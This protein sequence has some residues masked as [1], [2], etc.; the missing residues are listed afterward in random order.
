MEFL[1]SV[2]GK[3]VTGVVVLAVVAMGISWFQMDDQSR[4]DLLRG[5]G[6][7]IAW[8]GVVLVMPWIGFAV[9]NAVARRESNLA[10]GALIAAMTAIES[11]GLAWLFNW[12][13]TG[14]AAWMFFVLA[15]LIAGVYNLFTC[16][17]IAEK[18]A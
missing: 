1:K 15:V 14:A 7:I 4:G 10:G 6:R 8:L 3:A 13:I 17:W 11:A 12:S 16:D 2:T 5:G 18:M 9:I